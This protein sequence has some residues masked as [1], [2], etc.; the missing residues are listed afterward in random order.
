[1]SILKWKNFDELVSIKDEVERLLNSMFESTS[2]HSIEER[3]AL[4]SSG[5]PSPQFNIQYQDDDLVIQSEMPGYEKGDIKVSVS[6]SLLAIGSEVNREREFRGND[7]YKYHRSQGSFCKIMELPTGLDPSGIR[8]SFKDG[9]LEIV[10]P[11]AGRGMLTQPGVPVSV[12]PASSNILP[13][14]GNK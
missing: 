4:V 9:L 13:D 6:G 5:M 3:Y 14:R 7:A 8:T 1:M 11:K 2:F 12:G 10:I